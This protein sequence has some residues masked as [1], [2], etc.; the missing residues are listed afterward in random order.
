R[1]RGRNGQAGPTCI[2]RSPTTILGKLVECGWVER[3]PRPGKGRG[4]YGPTAKLRQ[5]GGPASQ[6]ARTGDLPAQAYVL[7]LDLIRSCVGECLVSQVAQNRQPIFGFD[8]L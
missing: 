2:R 5:L 6:P 3:V 7:R 4:W 8:P 1:G